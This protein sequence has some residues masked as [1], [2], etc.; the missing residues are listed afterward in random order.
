MNIKEKI[1]NVDNISLENFEIK[2]YSYH[3]KI[4]MKMRK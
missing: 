4:A 2:D 1:D 3:S